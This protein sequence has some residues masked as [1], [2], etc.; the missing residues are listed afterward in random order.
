M[1]FAPLFFIKHSPREKLILYVSIVVF[2]FFAIILEIFSNSVKQ[3]SK[4]NPY[5]ICSF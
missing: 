1:V 3:N 4:S 2:I 5:R